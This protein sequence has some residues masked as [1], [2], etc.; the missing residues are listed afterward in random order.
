MPITWPQTGYPAY[1]AGIGRRERHSTIY[2]QTRSDRNVRF[3]S[4][5]RWSQEMDEWFIFHF[6]TPRNCFARSTESIC[7]AVHVRYQWFLK[8]PFVAARSPVR[9]NLYANRSPIASTSLA[10]RHSPK[11]R[12][13]DSGVTMG[14]GGGMPPSIHIMGPHCPPPPQL[15]FDCAHFIAMPSSWP[16]RMKVWPPFGPLPK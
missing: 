15:T 16:P 8:T 13:W 5:Y 10:I 14:G 3:T 9:I 2:I 4:I 11:T 6:N 12:D 7:R 1:G